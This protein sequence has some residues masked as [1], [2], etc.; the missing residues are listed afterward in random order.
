MRRAWG[1][2]EALRKMQRIRS[3]SIVMKATYRSQCAFEE[4]ARSRVDGTF[5]VPIEFLDVF[6]YEACQPA[7]P[8]YF[9]PIRFMYALHHFRNIKYLSL[10]TREDR[11]D[12]EEYDQNHLL[13]VESTFTDLLGLR[14]DGMDEIGET[15]LRTNHKSLQY[16]TIGLWLGY[17]EHGELLNSLTFPSLKELQFNGNDLI[18]I[19]LFVE[20]ASST[21]L[22]KLALDFYCGLA[23]EST[24]DPEAMEHFVEMVLTNY[25]KLKVLKIELRF[26]DPDEVYYW[27][28]NWANGHKPMTASIFKG[29]EQGLMK[30]QDLLRDTFKIWIKT[31]LLAQQER[32][33]FMQS[34]QGMMRAL[35]SSNIGDFMIILRIDGTVDAAEHRECEYVDVIPAVEKEELDS[36]HSISDNIVIQ[37]I[38][39]TPCQ[40]WVISNK[41]CKMTGY[42]EQWMMS[43]HARWIGY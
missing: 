31:T 7:D 38:S 8:Y 23:N 19:I 20:S 40:K 14:F 35:I 27:D 24:T 17:P 12:E 13:M 28:A 6:I 3:L 39:P 11:I 16:L 21:N 36:L 42:S 22:E 25:L 32:V 10:T 5:P 2:Q 4:I 18:Q 9:S 15:L 26:D 37:K 33:Q 29:I 1:I 41:G 43:R 34:L 30:T